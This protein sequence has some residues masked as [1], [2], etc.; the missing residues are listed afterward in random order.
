MPTFEERRKE[1]EE[2]LSDRIESLE[3]EVGRLR[4]KRGLLKGQGAPQ[5]RINGVTR[6]I[7]RV[8]SRLEDYKAADPVDL[9]EEPDPTPRRYHSL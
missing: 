6:R 1:A 8:K 2:I 5:T 4:K 3:D 9:L 7:E